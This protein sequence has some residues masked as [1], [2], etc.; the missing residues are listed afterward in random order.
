MET[1]GETVKDWQ[2]E[3]IGKTILIYTGIVKIEGLI[4]Q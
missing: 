3:T 1:T 2:M 4:V